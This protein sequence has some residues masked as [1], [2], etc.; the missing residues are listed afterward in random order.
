MFTTLKLITHA[1]F[2]TQQGAWREWYPKIVKALLACQN[3]DGSWTG[4]HCITGRVFCTACSVVVL[5]TPDRL[6]PMGER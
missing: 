2:L 4:H 6:L 3:K 5:L 1:L